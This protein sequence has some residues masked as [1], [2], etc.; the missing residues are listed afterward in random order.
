MTELKP[1]RVPI[2]APLTDREVA[3]GGTY[4]TDA[5]L[6]NCY[7]ETSPDGRTF[8]VKRPGMSSAFTYNG[9][10]ATN[11]QGM[12]YH[13]AGLYAMGSNVL[14][15]LNGSA[16]G[17]ADGTTWGVSTTATWR[18]RQ[19]HAC[20]EFNG[21]I[22]ILGGLNTV[23]PYY[24]NDVW[25]SVDGVNWT[26]LTSAAP[27]AP[28]RYMGCVV[29]GDTMYIVGGASATFYND[30][31]STKDGVNWKQVVGS[32]A[33]AARRGHGCVPFN[34]GI[35]MM[36]G[37]DSAGNY[38][39]DVWFSPDGSTWTELVANASWSARYLFGCL[40]Y[41]G[42]VWVAG[43]TTAAATVATVYSSPDGLVWTNTGSLP[44][45]R[46]GM[47][48]TVYINKM[49]FIGGTD[50]A[51]TQQSTVYTSTDG[52]TFS[53]PTS[54]YGGGAIDG[55]TA[56]VWRTPTS[57]S[58]IHAPTIW[59]MGGSLVNVTNQIYR[60]TL[61]VALPSSFTISTG[62]ATTD[63]F[64]FTTQNAGQYLV[65]KNTTDAWVLY[66]GTAQ[67]I[68]STNYPQSTVPGIVN[69][70]DTVYVMDAA[71]VIYGSNLSTP[72]VWSSLNFI[73]ADYESDLGIAIA[74]YQ[75]YLVAFK[76]TSLQFFY[77]AGRYPGSPLLPDKNAT[78]RVGCASAAFIVPMDNTLVFMARTE[79]RGNYIAMLNGFM[80]TKISTPDI[81]R[82]LDSWLPATSDTAFSIRVNGH[83]FYLITLGGRDI[84]LAFDFI[85]KR[86]HIWRTGATPAK[87][88]ASNYATDGLID[89]LQDMAL[90]I[91]YSVSP[92]I[93]QDNS[94]AI[95]LSATG[96][97][98]DGGTN[99]RKFCSSLTVIGDRQSSTSPNTATVSWSDDDE[100][101][102]SSGVSVDLTTARP[103]VN[104]C[105]SFRRRTHRITHAA[106]NPFR[107]EAFELAL[108]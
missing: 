83:D 40:V 16:N 103:R 46:S 8:V 42:K 94:A 24:L 31:W 71:G 60:A 48:V 51:A 7:I 45:N 49:W 11:G 77:D 17:S 1:L 107:V 50:N 47:A 76:S 67:K 27:W 10:G 87:F 18:E 35:L 89:Y 98:V 6:I 106:N 63:Q 15:R 2:A 43:G 86:W 70:D 97:K 69:L 68:T 20:V 12:V 37:R 85:E 81:D 28:R 93:Y 23:A 96:V 65:F 99:E 41:A 3:K 57:V 90:G 34:N 102:F 105:G 33:W 78:S 54:N 64:K 38:Y 92:V 13:Q 29:L 55:A 61:N 9:G 88:R 72:F 5:M 108:R 104:R 58:A 62:G 79:Q 91:V 44:G 36:G 14:Y 32:A 84:T 66:A 100:V 95:T 19:G 56:I 101:T 74:K 53:T 39:N 4:A 73:T 30:V 26:Q 82:I 21:Q 80:P 25:A 52:A 59:L 22:F 75:N